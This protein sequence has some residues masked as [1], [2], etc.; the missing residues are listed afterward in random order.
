MNV[1]LN[2]LNK[3]LS[4]DFDVGGVHIMHHKKASSLVLPHLSAVISTRTFLYVVLC[5]VD[6]TDSQTNNQK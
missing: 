2:F 3:F 6:H 5:P 1:N 4:P